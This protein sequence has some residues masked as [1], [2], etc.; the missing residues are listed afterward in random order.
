M[1]VLLRA[2]LAMD[3]TYMA[4]ADEINSRIIAKFFRCGASR[5]KNLSDADIARIL[6]KTDANMRNA[7]VRFAHIIE[8]LTTPETFYA[9]PQLKEFASPKDSPTRLPLAMCALI[10]YGHDRNADAALRLFAALAVYCAITDARPL[11]EYHTI[12]EVGPAM[13]ETIIGALCFEY[14]RCENEIRDLFRI[15]ID[16][17][18]LCFDHGRDFVATASKEDYHANKY[19]AVSPTRDKT[20]DQMCIQVVPPSIHPGSSSM[21][22]TVARDA[23]IASVQ[24]SVDICEKKCSAASSCRIPGVLS[25]EKHDQFGPIITIMT[26]D[27]I[28]RGLTK[29]TATSVYRRSPIGAIC[30]PREMIIISRDVS[31]GGYRLVTYRLTAQIIQ[32]GGHFTANVARATSSSSESGALQYAHASDMMVSPLCDMTISPG[33]V[34]LFYVIVEGTKPCS[35]AHAQE[36]ML[37]ATCCALHGYITQ[38]RSQSITAASGIISQPLD[39]LCG[40]SVNC[41]HATTIAPEDLFAQFYS[42]A[43]STHVALSIRRTLAPSELKMLHSHKVGSKY[44]DMIARSAMLGNGTISEDRQ[45]TSWYFWTDPGILAIL[46]DPSGS[47]DKIRAEFEQRIKTMCDPLREFENSPNVIALP[48]CQ[49][50]VF[51]TVIQKYDFVG[52]PSSTPIS[53]S[54]I[55]TKIHRDSPNVPGEHCVMSAAPVSQMSPSYVPSIFQSTSLTYSPPAQVNPGD[56]P[57][58]PDAHTLAMAQVSEHE[59]ATDKNAP[60]FPVRMVRSPRHVNLENNVSQQSYIA[61]RREHGRMKSS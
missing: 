16:P 30:V 42:S 29:P 13:F 5:E 41:L 7:F 27:M 43:I 20:I 40:R 38:A 15:K 3:P 28:A 56:A 10:N 47:G 1:D 53:P 45:F 18:C 50:K 48:E 52:T 54:M 14:P 17:T 22:E 55:P 19:F 35:A 12:G 51:A 24:V 4:L 26:D 60:L 32:E 37:R 36:I 23:F 11:P 58:A 9:C 8:P 34:A 25:I 49:R 6:T 57:S 39:P 2:A 61:A 44:A 21:D 59:Y 46:Y 31:S 33:C